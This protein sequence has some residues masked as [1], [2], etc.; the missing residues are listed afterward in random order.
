MQG[1]HENKT[2]TP[3]MK[4]LL[5]FLIL[6]LLLLESAVNKETSCRAAE[7]NVIMS[8]VA[9]YNISA[10]KTMAQADFGLCDP[11]DGLT[12]VGLQ[13]WV[14]NTNGT[15][16]YSYNGGMATD[17]DV[18]WWTNWGQANGIKI[19]LTVYNNDGNWNWELA[20]SAFATN[21]TTLVNALL[22]EVDRLNLDGVDIDF[23][24]IGSFD[25]DRAAFN[26][27]V[28]E[29]S[30]G[31]KQRGKLL[32]ID[33][34][35][36]I[37]NAP[38]INWWSDWVGY[39]DNIHSMG[40]NELYEGGTD[41]HKYSVQ[42]YYGMNAGFDSKTVLMG[43]PAW[44][45]SMS[46][47]GVSSGRG[48]SAQAH[49]QE[50]RYDLPNGSTGI[51]IWDMQLL[52]WQNSE[53]WCEIAGL[54]GTSPVNSDPVANF[55]Y[56]ASDLN[57][58]F[59]ETSSDSDGTIVSWWWNF[60]DGITSA[61]RNPSHTYS[62]DGNYAV[63]LT[64][65]DDDGATDILTKTVSVCLDSD[66]DGACDTS[67]RCPGFDDRIDTDGDGV[68]DGCDN[69]ES[70]TAAF[71]PNP[72]THYG[73]GSNSAT[74]SFQ[75]KDRDVSFTISGISMKGGVPK[76]KYTEK[77][78]VTWSDGTNTLT[79][80]IFSAATVSA[81]NIS[82][83]GFVQSV[84]VRLEDGLDGDSGSGVMSIDFSPVS[85][86]TERETCIDSDNDGVCD[87]NDGCPDDPNKTAPGACGC[88]V[89]DTDLDRDG[90]PA[91]TDVNDNDPCIPN[92]DSPACN[93]DPCRE[94]I[95]DSFETGFGNW[96][97]GGLYVDRLTGTAKS[98]AY[99]IRLSDNE[100]AA[101]SLISNSLNLSA[102]SGVN[103]SFWYYPESME[104]GEDFMFEVSTNGGGLFSTLGNWV[105]GT[106]FTNNAWNAVQ[107]TVP[108][109]SAN[110]VF[111]IR[112]DAGD[113]KDKIY[114]DDITVTGCTGPM[115]L[116][117]KKSS[118]SPDPERLPLSPRVRIYPNPASNYLNIAF[119]HFEGK[120]TVVSLFNANGQLVKAISL[121]VNSR[122]VV[123]IDLGGFSG[124]LYLVRL[125]DTENK[126]LKSERVIIQDNR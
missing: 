105:A 70:K 59:A 83:P 26:V 50:V 99:S 125:T 46:S 34:F 38:N 91:C 25:S 107:L 113:R 54:K 22:S 53:L 73:L 52:G 103:V 20:R 43:M 85:Y 12:R 57:V 80:G 120:T 104:S 90:I 110:T 49:V 8:W 69:C 74:L 94:I 122:Q 111:R 68:P 24:G 18:A 123:Q 108:S 14:I 6:V 21:R 17:A 77:V 7:T 23:E 118:L 36:Y 30:T 97:D 88:G 98:G 84:T 2:K 5:P 102:F 119:E 55:S 79:Y 96:T 71:S 93:P 27:F 124:G 78:T 28:R 3:V 13:F 61:Q 9:P 87:T 31:L 45:T 100:G 32:T 65:T 76:S 39:V 72:L 4:I 56:S 117:P 35:P 44:S 42:Q 16:K 86:C 92:P 89:A 126:I 62:V 63:S 64:V 115:N 121:D 112:C 19:L 66:N 11:K 15:I 48:T 47:W 106:H 82:I 60:G 109:F 81:A 40:Y 51:A 95:T 116:I 41:W 101:S 1:T 10:C 67:D 58:V 37:W 33:S 114:I 29:L 75:P